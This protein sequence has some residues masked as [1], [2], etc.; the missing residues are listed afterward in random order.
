MNS[1]NGAAS[2]TG[3]VK[4]T[5]SVR[6]GTPV[7]AK[8]AA[9]KP[10]KDDGAPEVDE[11]RAE[12][13]SKLDEMQER[14]NQA[15]ATAEEQEKAKAVLQV[16]LDEASKEQG[17]LEENVQ[18]HIERIEELE[19][20]KKESLR[21]QREME[22]IYETE[23][24]ATLKEKE[25]TAA[26]EEEMQASMQRMKESLAQREMRQGLDDEK[27]PT[28][29]RHSSW[30]QSANA[31][32]NPENGQFAPPSSLQRSDSRSSSKIVNQ[33]DKIIEGLRLDLAEAEFKLV[34]MEN[35]GGGRLQELQ[36]TV[37]DTKMQNARLMEENESF[38]LLLQEKTLNGDFSIGHGNLLRPASNAGSRPS[39]RHHTAGGTTLADEL[40]SNVDDSELVE[41]GTES[42]RRLQAE[43]NS[44]KEQNKALTLYINNIVSRLLQHDQFEHILDKT[45]DIMS[46]N[47]PAKPAPAKTKPEEK[48][49]PPPPPEKDIIP[50]PAL[51]AKDD[52]PPQEP[53][54]FLQ[55]A[56]SVVVGSTKSRPRPLSQA[57]STQSPQPAPTPTTDDH[58]KP[59]EN[60]TTA[61]Q[62]PLSRS[63]SNRLS[64]AP[65][66]RRAQSEWASANAVNN[67][68]RGPTT[69]GNGPLS[70]GL[71]SPNQRNSFFSPSSANLTSPPTSS[72]Q[73]QGTRAVSGASSAAGGAGASVP[74]TISESEIPK[75]NLPPS[76]TRD[77][78][79]STANPAALAALDGSSTQQQ[80]AEAGAAAA[81]EYNPAS[82]PRSTVSSSGD[83]SQRD[84]SGNNPI[85]MG[86]KMRPLRLVQEAA[87][88]SE[89][90]RKAANRGSWFGWMGK[91]GHQAPAP[92]GQGRSFSGGQAGE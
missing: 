61:P 70:P 11:V 48:E 65:G 80:Q 30:R 12:M 62:I 89:R 68:Y 14:L 5:K 90:E 53:Q 20:E 74:S 82:P 75:E 88:E 71:T 69:P 28:V 2:A 83:S 42:D 36:K 77:S 44:L 21:Q 4:G 57:P 84:R 86:S 58:Q 64:G 10:S 76:V 8:A 81:A 29:S 6:T 18:E 49:L 17:I 78:K 63:K 32:P 19:R 50:P 24:A 92:Q 37:Y 85:M 9:R 16:K 46:G 91:G 72:G 26:R 35:M 73:Q 38:Q 54:G 55:R 66:H 47:G 60:P 1:T 59:T 34:E 40:E 87:G 25:A 43:I 33:K 22:H 67:M 3:G 27:R 13:Q 23:R 79:L 31:S 51:P 39:S 45:P 52:P 15:E 7:S 56:K 41:A